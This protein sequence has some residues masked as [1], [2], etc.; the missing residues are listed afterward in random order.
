VQ[1]VFRLAFCVALWTTCAASI[2][3]ADDEPPPNHWPAPFGGRFHAAFTVASDY[4]Q[5]GISNTQLGPAFQA[6][7]DYRS[8][9]LLPKGDPP[10]W[11]YGYVFG[12]NV[13]FPNAGN[14]TEIDVAGGL[15]L[16]LLREKLSFQL[17]YIRYLYPDLSAQYGLEFGEVEF[18]ADYD[19]GPVTAGGRLRWSP[20]GLG[21]IG[22]TWNKRGL[23]SAPLSFLPLPFDASMRVYGALGNFWMEKPEAQGLLAN[24]YWYWQVGLVTSVWGLDFT[25]AYT[26][27][28]LEPDGCGN[29]RL[30][31][32]R[33]FFSMT[34]MF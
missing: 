25:V 8:P 17:G 33:V 16:R 6:S 23:V 5:T 32:G 11:I 30:C 14:G 18:K 4:A 3:R 24:D 12:S 21:G 31:A 26:D 34:K 9:Y 1:S 22:Q 10:L 20:S 28:N 13:S 19:F 2:A 7:L 27:T 29:T 15:K